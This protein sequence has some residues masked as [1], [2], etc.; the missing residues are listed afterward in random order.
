MSIRQ[1]YGTRC[2]LCLALLPVGGGQCAH[3]IDQSSSKGGQQLRMNSYTDTKHIL[4]SFSRLS[5]W[6]SCLWIFEGTLQTMGFSVCTGF[7]AEYSAANQATQDARHVIKT[8]SLEITF[9]FP[10]P[11]PYFDTSMTSSATH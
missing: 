2:A 11:Y 10:L 3:I 9:L 4:L 1:T 7:S 6:V 5:V 8:I